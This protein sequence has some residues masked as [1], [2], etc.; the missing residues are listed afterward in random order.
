MIYPQYSEFAGKV[1]L[2]TGAGDGIGRATAI[3]FARNGARVVVTDINDAGGEETVALIA[4]RGGTAAFCRC[5]VSVDADHRAAVGFAVTTY[6]GLDYAFNNAGFAAP[7]VPLAETGQAQVDR[8]IEVNLKGVWS[9]MRHQIAAMLDRGGGAIVNNAST[10]A[11]VAL[12][13][14]AVYSGCKSAVVAMSRAAAVDYAAANVRVNS[15]CPG[16]TE[17][18]ELRPLLAEFAD[19]PERLAAIRAQQVVDRWAQPEEIAEPV[20]FLCSDGASYIVGASLLA[21]GGYTL[22]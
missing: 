4:A 1:A 21:D 2:V 19:Q 22:R 11:H 10:L 13:G 14:R 6:G 20:L 9:A 3:A 15:I 12:A 7:K 17:T 18:G 8:L 5:D 16:T